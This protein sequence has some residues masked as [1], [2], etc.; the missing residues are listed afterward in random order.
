MGE[1]TSAASENQ[2]A[3]GIYNVE[4]TNNTYAL[5]IGNGT[6][7]SNRSNAATIARN[8][9][10]MAQAMA[11]IMQMFAGTVTQTVDSSGVATATGAPAGWLLCDGS[12][13]S[14]VTYATLYAVI[15]DT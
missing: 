9:N 7:S 10:Y 3:L 14:R 13:V 11:G 12:A 6:D 1:G 15:G 2:T 4:D 5:I 8:G